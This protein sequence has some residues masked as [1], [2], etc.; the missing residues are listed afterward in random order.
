[1]FCATEAAKAMH[2][3]IPPFLIVAGGVDLRKA[4]GG[5]CLRQC[6]RS[7]SHVRFV[8]CDRL[9]D[10]DVFE[11]DLGHSPDE[12]CPCAC[13]ISDM[14][15]AISCEWTYCSKVKQLQNV[16]TRALGVPPG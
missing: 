15:L 6:K 4:W 11:F 8:Y 2:S 10:F 13:K 3:S 16:A 12:K 9:M 1:M 7:I 5:D 14:E